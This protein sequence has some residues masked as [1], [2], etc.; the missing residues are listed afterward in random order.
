[1]SHQFFVCCMSLV[2]RSRKNEFNKC[3]SCFDLETSLRWLVS[4]KMSQNSGIFPCIIQL[5]FVPLQVNNR[6][7][8]I[9]KTKEM[10][11]NSLQKIITVYNLVKVGGNE[12]YPYTYTD[13]DNYVDERKEF[14]KQVRTH[15]YDILS[16][17]DWEFQEKLEEYNRVL[18]LEAKK[19]GESTYKKY[20]TKT[21]CVCGEWLFFESEY[22]TETKEVAIKD[23]RGGQREGS[24]RKSRHSRLVGGSMT[25]VIRIPKLEKK[26]IKDLI[27]WLIDKAEEEKDIKSSLYSAQRALEEKGDKEDAQLLEELR[28]RLPHFSVRKVEE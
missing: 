21:I 26:G 24:G 13:K 28:S 19:H 20:E 1:M 7:C 3:L 17:K 10:K 23:C 15:G 12:I 27:D 18:E 22:V 5:F 9:I 16:S 14:V 25:A 6:K 8:N 4:L 2:C 11:H